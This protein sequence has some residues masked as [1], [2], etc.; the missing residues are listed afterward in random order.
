ML[1]LVADSLEIL[2]EREKNVIIHRFGLNG[3]PKVSLNEV[4]NMYSITRERVRQIEFKAE[5]KILSHLMQI[6]YIT[7]A[8]YNKL[9]A[10]RFKH[11]KQKREHSTRKH[12]PNAD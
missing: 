7:R 4:G 3:F 2:S 11:V 6:H 12:P 10:T 8:Q 1:E 5:W 9:L